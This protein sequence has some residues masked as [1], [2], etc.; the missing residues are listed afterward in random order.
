MMNRR[1][2]AHG[3]VFPELRRLK[4]VFRNGQVTTDDGRLLFCS[5]FSIHHS[6]LLGPSSL[7][8]IIQHS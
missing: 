5:S 7:L 3:Q 4:D 2:D 1:E 6:S 8:F